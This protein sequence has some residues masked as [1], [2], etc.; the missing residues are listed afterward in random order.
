MAAPMLRCAHTPT[1]LLLGPAADP[2]QSV[3]PPGTDSDSKQ[4]GQRP[5]RHVL[6]DWTF[7]PSNQR[8]HMIDDDDATDESHVLSHLPQVGQPDDAFGVRLQVA[9]LYAVD[10][11]GRLHG[12][13]LT[14]RCRHEW[15]CGSAVHWLASLQRRCMPAISCCNRR[16]SS[17][18]STSR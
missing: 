3:S 6:H 10:A 17:L 18:G 1:R 4:L 7:S 14:F 11:A 12:G 2:P 8:Q 5:F 9:K 13:M 16:S 15:H